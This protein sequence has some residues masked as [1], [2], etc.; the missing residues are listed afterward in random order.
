MSARNPTQPIPGT[1]RLR[2]SE[3]E[4]RLECS[5]PSLW[6]TSISLSRPQPANKVTRPLTLPP[7][8][9]SAR[10]RR[11]TDKRLPSLPTVDKPLPL[12]PQAEKP[13]PSLPSALKGR[14]K[15]RFSE[16]CGNGGS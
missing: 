15:G 9:F 8:A 14:P 1:V 16:D 12:L 3:L 6:R 4:Q 7:T 5:T 10:R 2:L 11:N 13:L